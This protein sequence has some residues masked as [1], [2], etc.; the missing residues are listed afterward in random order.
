[1]NFLL[2]LP[3]FSWDTRERELLL[4][5]RGDAFSEGAREIFEGVSEDFL[6]GAE[7]S[8]V[9][10]AARRRNYPEAV[11]YKGTSRETSSPRLG[12]ETFFSRHSAQLIARAPTICEWFSS[13]VLFVSSRIPVM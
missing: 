9:S 1:M 3:S 13:G 8:R 12:A 11:L 7:Q 6:G 10:E 5:K 4:P 2:F